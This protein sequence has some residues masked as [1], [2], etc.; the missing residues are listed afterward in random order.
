MNNL[1]YAYLVAQDDEYNAERALQ[2]INEALRNLPSGFDPAEASKFLHTK[3]TAL[4]QQDRLQE[5]LAVYERALKARPY[6]PDTLRSLIECYRGLNKLP[7]EQYI[8]RLDLIEQK[9][10]EQQNK[11]TTP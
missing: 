1:S 10:R 5:A 11:V 6:H 4:K 7:P 2:L 8:E 9:M 3:A